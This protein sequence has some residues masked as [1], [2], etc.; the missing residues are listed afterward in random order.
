M[1][2]STVA[3]TTTSPLAAC[4]ERIVASIAALLSASMMP[5]KSLTGWVSGGGNSCALTFA[6]EITKNTL[7]R[8]QRAHSETRFAFF[9]IDVAETF[10]VLVAK[11]CA[12]FAAR[13]ATC[14]RRVRAVPPRRGSRERA[15]R[16]PPRGC[17]AA[18]R[19]Q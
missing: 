8:T 17:L 15:S 1:K 18:A 13:R 12:A 3:T 4:S 19:G 16:D 2:V 11:T 5:A 6:A 14:R 10:G 7:H 9:V